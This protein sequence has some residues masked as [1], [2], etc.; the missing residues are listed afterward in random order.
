MRRQILP[1][2]FDFALFGRLF[3]VAL[4]DER[5][6]FLRRSPALFIA[7]LAFVLLAVPYLY[8]TATLSWWLDDI[9]YRRH[10][11]QQIKQ[12]VFIIGNPR[13]GTTFLHR[14][15]ARDEA[16][17]ATFQTWEM[18]FAPTVTQRKF[19]WAVAAVDKLIGRPLDRIIRWIDKRT[20]GAVKFH[21]T[22]LHEVEEDEVLLTYV[23]NSTFSLGVFP[24]PNEALPE[25]LP[26]DELPEARARVMPFYRDALKRHFFAHGADQRQFLSKNPVFSSRVDAL[27]ETFPDAR[28]IYLIRSPLNVLGSLSSYARVVWR[29][30]LGVEEDFPYD[31]AIWRVVHHWYRYTMHR[32]EQAPPE[33]Y[34][35]VNFDE[36]TTHPDNVVQRIYEHFG[37]EVSEEYAETLREAAEK[38][39]QYES[40]HAYSF[41]ETAF[42]RQQILEEYADLFERFGFETG[43]P[44]P[45]TQH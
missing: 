40:K 19:S 4:F 16:T 42:T 44:H 5:G 30:I 17:F 28:F 15:M 29:E 1:I 26:F 14:L 11:D 18:A 32:L 2:P 35:I 12:P 3:R 20:L 41:E 27:Y 34:L 10:R 45:T 38:A 23:W 6:R 9:L 22:G 33:S 43:E 24:F 7:M 39:R 13:S 31:D 21:P 37:L 8:I 36:V 25:I